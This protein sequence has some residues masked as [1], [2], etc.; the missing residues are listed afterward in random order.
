MAGM[1][2]IIV[3]IVPWTVI[4]H[5]NF[6]SDDDIKKRDLNS[7]FVGKESDSGGIIL[8]VKRYFIII[9]GPIVVQRPHR[10]PVRL[11]FN[12]GAVIDVVMRV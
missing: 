1:G 3:F 6:L 7:S 12:K 8:E 5:V 11:L 9:E 10:K 4:D 2:F